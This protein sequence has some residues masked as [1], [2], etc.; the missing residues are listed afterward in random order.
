MAQFY[1][2]SVFI[3]IVA[4]LTLAGDYLGDRIAF[5]ASFKSLRENRVSMIVIGLIGATVG[6]ITFFIRAPGDSVPVVGDLL[7]SLAGIA[8]GLA[9]LV[10]AFRQKVESRGTQGEKLS[11]AVLTY[12]VP[13]GIAG[14]AIAV[15]HFLVPA[16]VIL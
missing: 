3:N 7:P 2:L 16:A 15:L 14:V 6:V 8:Q 12:R 9:L 11:K 4:G 1:L 5:L 13:A 10:E